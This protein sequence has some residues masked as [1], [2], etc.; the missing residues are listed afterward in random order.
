MTL[1]GCYRLHYILMPS[2]RYSVA[3]RPQ[4][5]SKMNVSSSS[6]GQNQSCNNNEAK[7]AHAS[8]GVPTYVYVDYGAGCNNC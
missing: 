5:G 8:K 7:V 3:A 2:Q 1:N 4:I 6:G